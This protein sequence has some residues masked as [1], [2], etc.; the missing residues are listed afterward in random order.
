M[1]PAETSSGT[2]AGSSAGTLLLAKAHYPVTTLGPGTRAGIWTQGC[3]LHCNGCLS[4]DTWDAD[5]RKAVPVETV[6]GWLKSL[7]GRVDGVTISGG[8]P[9]QQ[10][11]ALAALLRGVRAW[12]DGHDH[13]TIALD[14]LVYSGYVYSRLSRTAE[15]R[16]ILDMCDAVIAGPYVDRLNP[17]G[18]TPEA[19]LYSGG[20]RPTSVSCRSPRW[21]AS[22]TGH[23][24]T[25]GRLRK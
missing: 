1:T 18:D 19:A 6:L 23:W 9:F 8:E 15:T 4:R 3:T 10:P 24:P 21:G 16:E 14:I 7:P 13:E 12:R 2:S 20:G 11:A 17:G 25:S 22:G 5:P